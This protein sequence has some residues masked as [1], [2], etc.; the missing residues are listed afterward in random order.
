[1]Q[2][3]LETWSQSCRGRSLNVFRHTGDC[4]VEFLKNVSHSIAQT[5]TNAA[6]CRIPSQNHTSCR[7]GSQFLRR[8]LP[9]QCG[10]VG[11]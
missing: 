1:M 4:A 3:H 10:A 7:V 5:C 11:A 6:K 2:Q 8:C 9:R